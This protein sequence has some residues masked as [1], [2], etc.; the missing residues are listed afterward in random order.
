LSEILRVERIAGESQAQGINPSTVHAI[1][2]LVS[3]DIAVARFLDRF[4][5]RHF[6]ARHGYSFLPLD[7]N[8]S[9]A[10]GMT[11]CTASHITRNC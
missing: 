4:G 6:I 10:Q 3:S 2:G 7:L 11:Q 1:E 8:F 5:F 9:R